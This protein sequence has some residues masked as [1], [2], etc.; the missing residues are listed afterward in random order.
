MYM[1]INVMFDALLVYKNIITEDLKISYK[2]SDK[3]CKIPHKNRVIL[4][5]TFVLVG[6]IYIYPQ[7]NKK[8]F[9]QF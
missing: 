6:Y 8:R 7:T 4:Y 3:S 2:S 1:H 9:V 5:K